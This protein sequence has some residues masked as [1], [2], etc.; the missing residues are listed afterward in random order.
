MLSFSGVG[1][2]SD[3]YKLKSVGDR[4]PP[5]GTPDLKALCL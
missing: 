1:G 4:I 5:C 3:V 2:R